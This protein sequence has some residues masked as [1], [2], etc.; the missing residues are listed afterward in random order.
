MRKGTSKYFVPS[1]FYLKVPGYRSVFP[2]L[3]LLLY[4]FLKLLHWSFHSFSFFSF[5]SLFLSAF[6]RPSPGLSLVSGLTRF[7]CRL[8]AATKPLP[9]RLLAASQ[10][11]PRRRRERTVFLSGCLSSS[12]ILPPLLF[13]LFLKGLPSS[14]HNLR[15]FCLSLGCRGVG[16]CWRNR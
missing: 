8:P 1:L 7:P 3:L 14:A 6:F 12:S 15:L 2:T 4:F 13:L 16:K 9:C 10:P 11:P 5:F